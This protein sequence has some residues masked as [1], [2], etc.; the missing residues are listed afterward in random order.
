MS[1]PLLNPQIPTGEETRVAALLEPIQA[2]LGFVPDGLRLYTVSPPLL[3]TFVGT[4]G[5]FNTESV[6]GPRLATMIRYLVSYR[7]DCSFCIDLNEGF[8]TGMGLDL[9][10]VRAARDNVDV[11]PVEPPELPLL[12]L[13]L[14][15][16]SDT[17]E[18]GPGDVE[19]AR[20]AGWD[21]RGIFEAV[22]VATGNR[23]FNQLLRA[24]KVEHQGA[25][26]A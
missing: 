3:E 6:L 19:A 1:K 14:K 7:S 9:D 11:A 26:A 24:F 15:A 2:R 5:Y 23:A 17:E 18:V 21:D 4:V 12:R 13:A 8:L 22:A 16:L 25:F 10:A 20:D